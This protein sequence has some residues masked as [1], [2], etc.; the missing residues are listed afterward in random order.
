MNWLSQLAFAT[1]DLSVETR[2]S[3]VPTNYRERIT[4]AL[5]SQ[6]AHLII[7][8]FLFCTLPH[9][10]IR[11]VLDFENIF[12]AHQSPEHSREVVFASALDFIG[13]P[14]LEHLRCCLR[15]GVGFICTLLLP[16][17]TAIP[18]PSFKTIYNP[19][20]PV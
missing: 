18:S 3:C 12:I 4:L 14:S 6:T 16:S 5:S 9:D 7:V 20:I 11:S 13:Y 15:V 10:H 1:C 19:Y 8:S 17:I 2:L